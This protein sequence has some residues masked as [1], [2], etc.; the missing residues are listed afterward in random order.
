MVKKCCI[1]LLLLF[2]L[3]FWA[4]C[5]EEKSFISGEGTALPPEPTV[6][7]TTEPEETW[8]PLIENPYGPMDFSY[9]EDRVTC[10]A[11]ESILGID[12]SEWQGQIDWDQVAASGVSFVIIRAAW[13]GTDE[14]GLNPD[15]CAQS[16]YEGAKAAGLKVGAY[17]FSQ[18]ISP[19]EAEEEAR[20]L[21]AQVENW[22]LD[23]PLIMDWE[24]VS[25]EARSAEVS[26][27]T[28]TDS[29]R[30]FCETVKA[31][32]YT[33]MIYFNPGQ[34]WDRMYLYELGE[35]DFWLAMYDCT[36]DF[37]YRVDMWQ[38]TGNGTV[39]GIDTPVDMN[40]WFTYD[41]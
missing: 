40:L 8:E 33:P 31:A 22:E 23:L 30:A 18:A 13:R 5:S 3:L 14:G 25:E 35:Y 2:G 21:M 34:I 38:Y 4:G 6:R 36:M 11:G 32:G 17:I 9:D 26:A 1:S 15:A 39:P 19:E 24:Y 27:R 28:L 7:P 41:E 20:Y 29:Y 16:Y 12:V 10:L 37:P